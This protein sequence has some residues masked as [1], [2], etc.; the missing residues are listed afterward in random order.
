MTLQYGAKTKLNST[1]P[2][3]NVLYI[4]LCGWKSTQRGDGGIMAKRL[5]PIWPTMIMPWAGSAAYSLG[6]E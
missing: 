5:E 4:S 6:I 3:S 2:I 1:L